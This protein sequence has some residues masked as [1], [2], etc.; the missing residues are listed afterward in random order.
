MPK[1]KLHWWILIGIV[2]GFVSG[3]LVLRT[4]GVEAATQTAAYEAFDGISRIFLNLLKLIDPQKHKLI[5]SWRFEGDVLVGKPAGVG[6]RL[7]IPYPLPA[8]Y[9]LHA[10]VVRER[11]NTN[12]PAVT[13]GLAGDLATEYLLVELPALLFRKL[14]GRCGMETVKAPIPVHQKVHRLWGGADDELDHVTVRE[15]LFP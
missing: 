9:D 7:H 12:H 11:S 15:R 6:S 13:V 5:G 8:E 10:T 14:S 4:V 3:W 1:L 2:L